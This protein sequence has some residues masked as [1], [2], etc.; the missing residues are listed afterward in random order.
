MTGNLVPLLT[1]DADQLM[2]KMPHPGEDHRHPV[3]IGGGN[4]LGI[5]NGSPRLDQRGDAVF[6]ALIHA[7]PEGEEGI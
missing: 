2:S 1:F 6:R 4:H 3:L 7:V 5:P